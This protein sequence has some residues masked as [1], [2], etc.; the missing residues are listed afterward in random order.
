M[1]R[2]QELIQEEFMQNMKLANQT[3][4]NYAK[5]LEEKLASY[6]NIMQHCSCFK[7]EQPSVMSNQEVY[8][9]FYEDI[10]DTL[11]TTIGR[12]YS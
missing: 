12:M 10:D 11:W 7:A 8:D 2:K 1:E 9:E 3:L 4:R 5:S 6:E